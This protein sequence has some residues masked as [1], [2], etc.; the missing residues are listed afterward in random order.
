MLCYLTGMEPYY[1]TCI[2]DDPFQ[3]KTVEGAKKPEAYWR[4]SES[5]KA[6]ITASTTAPIST[7]FFSNNIIQDFQENFDDEVDERTRHI[8]VIYVRGSVFAESSQSSE[9][10]VGLSCNTYGSTVH[11]TTDNSDFEHFERG[12]R[13]HTVKAKEP[14]KK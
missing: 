11:S 13:V 5:K 14:T 4:Y 6:L 12:E 2:K 3:R 8:R 9:S 1:I 10:S 7:A